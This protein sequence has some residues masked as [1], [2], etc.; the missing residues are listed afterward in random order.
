MLRVRRLVITVALVASMLPVMGA[1]PALAAPPGGCPSGALC[2]HWDS[3]YRGA[4]YRFFGTNSSWG[5]WAIENDDSSW[6]NNGTSGMGVRVHWYRGQGG[7]SQCWDRGEGELISLYNQ[8]KG[9][10]NVWVSR[11]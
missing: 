4:Q 7:P 3:Y 2:V 6:F 10:S 5:P 8:D 1:L 9:S 11:C